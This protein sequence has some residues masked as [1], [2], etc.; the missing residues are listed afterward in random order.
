MTKRLELNE[1]P[2]KG[3]QVGE[4]VMFLASSFGHTGMDFGFYRGL[5]QFTPV[6]EVF[7]RERKYRWN[8]ERQRYVQDQHFS[9]SSRRV[10]LKLRRVWSADTIKERIGITPSYEDLAKLQDTNDYLKQS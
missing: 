2:Y 7:Y 3:I 4:K 9:I 1:V 5:S 8:K 6:V 10:F